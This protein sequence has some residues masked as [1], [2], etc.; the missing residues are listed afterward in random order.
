MLDQNL[1]TMFFSL[2]HTKL[3]RDSVHRPTK[4]IHTEFCDVEAPAHEVPRPDVA[5]PTL[6]IAF[7]NKEFGKANTK[8][9]HHVCFA[10]G[11]HQLAFLSSFCIAS[12][13]ALVNFS[14]S[15]TPFTWFGL[16]MFGPNIV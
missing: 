5:K 10:F 12:T 9:P 13:R 8:I 14:K 7:L 3:Y 15:V 16:A 1:F 6:W 2:C 4:G 11:R